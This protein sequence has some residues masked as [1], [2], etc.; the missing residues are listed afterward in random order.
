MPPPITSVNAA[1]LHLLL[2]HIP[3]VGAVVT[4]GILILAFI[5][6]DEPLKLVGLEV[7]FMI[8]LLTLP[9]YMSGVAAFLA[10]WNQPG[11][12]EDAMRIHQ[13]AAL[14]GFTVT[15][16]AGFIAWVALWQ[17]QT[18]RPHGTRARS[19]RRRCC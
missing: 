15:E 10:L 1:H 13:D 3:T 5:R 14:A 7:L 16:F 17:C 12:S 2:N 6:R 4:L 9:A 18:P 19:L 8:A 11:V